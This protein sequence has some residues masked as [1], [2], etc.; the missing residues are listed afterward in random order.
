MNLWRHFW[1]RIAGR[2]TGNIRRVIV[3]V[4]Q[5]FDWQRAERYLDEGLLHYLPL[6]SDIGTQFELRSAAVFDVDSSAASLRAAG[7]RVEVLV[8]VTT[9]AESN[10]DDICATD[11]LQQEQLFNLLGRRRSRVVIAEFNML[12][13]V[14]RL[15][16]PQPTDEQRL[17][18]RDVHAR[19]DEHVGKVFS[20][21]DSETALV[22][23]PAWCDE[24]GPMLREPDACGVFVSR[25]LSTDE[26]PPTSLVDLVQK[27]VGSAV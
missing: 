27:L 25:P 11:R 4:L 18:L 19:M 10:L 17:V 5:G 14:R 7:S 8:S 20:F 24:S 3:L 23:I 26:L 2:P 21:V 16:G 9:P 12:S 15:F 13:R 6:L 1:D 22:V